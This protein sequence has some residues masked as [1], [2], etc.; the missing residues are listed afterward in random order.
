[1][2]SVKFLVQTTTNP[3]HI[4]LRLSLSKTDSVKRK[5]GYVIDPKLW[6]KK[7]GWPK[8]KVAEGKNTK[9]DLEELE[10]A[11]LTGLNEATNKGLEITGEWLQDQINRYHGKITNEDEE[12]L[13]NC[14]Q[15]YI[16]ALPTMKQP[17]G[18][19]GVS[20]NTIKKYR[21]F[22]GKIEAFEKYRGKNISVRDVSTKLAEE[23]DSYFLNVDK[24]KGST[25]GKYIKVLKTVATWANNVKGIQAHK[26]LKGIKGYSE[27]AT[28]VFLNFD[29][30]EKI[31]KAVYKRKALDNARNWLIIGCYIGQRVSDL[32][33]LNEDNLVARNG[34]ELIELVQQKTGKRVAIPLHEKVKAILAKNNGKFPHKTSD[35]KFNLHLKDV[36]ELAGITEP[37]EGGKMITNKVTGITRKQIG[38]FPKYQLVTSHICRRS[39]ATNFYGDIPTSI[40]INITAHS[41]EKQFREYIGKASDDYAMQL[42]EYWNKAQLMAKKTPQLTVL[43]K[44]GND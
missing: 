7:T 12:R 8:Q 29:E 5:T 19:K 10:K 9:S 27:K 1:M 35:V 39:F 36:C 4:Y 14:I 30:L 23:L 21:A 41:T 31:E 28:K 3:A 18:S 34:V 37:V 13:L 44:T 33:S 38:I 17:N 25:A 22:K 24:L 16:D 11:I 42:A 20:L 32:L 15:A 26:S 6:S 40:L 2:A 43:G